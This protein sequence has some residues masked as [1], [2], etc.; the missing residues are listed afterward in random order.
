MDNKSRKDENGCEF[1]RKCKAYAKKDSA[2]DDKH[3]TTAYVNCQE[4]QSTRL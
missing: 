4:R 3:C 2:F 1:K